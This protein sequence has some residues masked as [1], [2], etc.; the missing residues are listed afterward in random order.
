MFFLKTRAFC[1]FL[2][3]GACCSSLFIDTHQLYV[4][5]KG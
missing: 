5:D 2:A 4:E 1:N 3:I